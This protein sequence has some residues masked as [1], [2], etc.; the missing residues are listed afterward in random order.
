MPGAGQLN[1]DVE[2]DD[3]VFM[4]LELPALLERDSGSCSPGS[5]PVSSHCPPVT[6]GD[7]GA[8]QVGGSMSELSH[9]HGQPSMVST[10]LQRSR[11][12]G[13]PSGHRHSDRV[14]RGHPHGHR[15]PGLP[16]AD[17][18]P[19]GDNIY[20]WLHKSEHVPLRTKISE[21]EFENLDKLKMKPSDKNYISLNNGDH[22]R[23]VQLPGEDSLFGD[24]NGSDAY[25]KLDILPM[26]PQYHYPNLELA[27]KGY[28][29][30]MFGL[31]STMPM[32]IRQFGALTVFC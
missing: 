6:H 22:P 30:L 5:S 23:Y 7:P 14:L 29:S 10:T 28:V 31:L 13:A 12:I 4:Q 25:V 19:L 17:P 1:K 27:T 24:I 20:E 21:E 16:S 11:T 2:Q 9:D 32:H 18:G 15:S 3:D 8:D 26:E